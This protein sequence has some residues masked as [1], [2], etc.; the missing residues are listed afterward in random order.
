[1]NGIIGKIPKIEL[2]LSFLHTIERYLIIS[3]I[4]L[5]LMILTIAV[6][7]KITGKV[8]IK[9][10]IRVN[11][12]SGDVLKR[13]LTTSKSM[14]YKN[15]NDINEKIYNGESTSEKKSV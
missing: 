9:N 5:I 8:F 2:S 13:I 11:S 10:K 6:I 7:K 1:M 4:V 14:N 12:I 15:S 3:S